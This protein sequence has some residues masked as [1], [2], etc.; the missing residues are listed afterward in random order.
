MDIRFSCSQGHSLAVDP[1]MAGRRVKCPVCLEIVTAPRLAIPATEEEPD[2]CEEVQYVDAEEE[3]DYEEDRSRRRRG[4]RKVRYEDEEEEERRGPTRRGKLSKQDRLGWVKLGLDFHLWKYVCFVFGIVIG[5]MGWIV[6]AIPLLG[7]AVMLG[8]NFIVF[9][10]FILG[11]VGSIFCSWVPD[12][13]QARLLVLLA[14]GFDVAAPVVLVLAFPL[15]IVSI[16]LALVFVLLAIVCG[17]TG[18][19]LFM[20]FVKKLAYYLH[21]R[22][23]GDEAIAAMIQ[24]LAVFF[25]GPVIVFLSA[26]ILLMIPVFGVVL[27][28]AG[29]IGWLVLSVLTLF[30]I[31]TVLKEVRSQ[32]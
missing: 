19:A 4:P 2:D 5:M 6:A 14:L 15:A 28:I 30:R 1:E 20:V 9:V 3:D 29:Y 31:L 27:W 22:P 13:A 7:L 25:G 10:A 21:D 23:D 24:A 11:V 32:I 16:V 12:K 18:F 26:F 8:S 17:S